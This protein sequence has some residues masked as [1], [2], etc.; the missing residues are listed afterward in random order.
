M[1]NFIIS[2]FKKIVLHK[3]QFVRDIK[4]TFQSTQ[5]LSLSPDFLN[6]S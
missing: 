2:T 3:N 1:S 6:I 4:T 5:R